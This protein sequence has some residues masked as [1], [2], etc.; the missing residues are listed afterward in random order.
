MD[1]DLFRLIYYIFHHCHNLNLI[2]VL[3]PFVSIMLYIPM[4]DDYLKILNDDEVKDLVVKNFGEYFKSTKEKLYSKLCEEQNIRKVA[5]LFDI[6]LTTADEA[7]KY[8]EIIQL[9][10]S[11]N[12]IHC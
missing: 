10:S 12:C 11:N 2:K 1:Y 9:K 5:E 3:F 6:V 7:E 4:I 8:V